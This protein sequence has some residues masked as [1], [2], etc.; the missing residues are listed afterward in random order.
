SAAV[1]AGDETAS[2]IVP[3]AKPRIES[4]RWVRQPTLPTTSSGTPL[5]KNLRIVGLCLP[6]RSAAKI[7]GK[8]GRQFGDRWPPFH[9]KPLVDEDRNNLVH[10]HI[11]TAGEILKLIDHCRGNAQG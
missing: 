2:S 1:P 10:A 11:A 6:L 5:L 8:P 9:G 4:S 7:I 3:A